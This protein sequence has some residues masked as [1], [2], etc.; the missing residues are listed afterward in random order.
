[1]ANPGEMTDRMLNSFRSMS[2]NTTQ[3]HHLFGREK[4][5]YTHEGHPSMWFPSVCVCMCN[6]SVRT[7][8]LEASIDTSMSPLHKH[9]RTF[10]QHSLISQYNDCALSLRP[11]SFT[12]LSALS[13]KNVKYQV[14]LHIH[15]I[16]TYHWLLSV[17]A[18]VKID[19]WNSICALIKHKTLEYIWKHASEF[20]Y[21]LP[22]H[23]VLLHWLCFSL[24]RTRQTDYRTFTNVI[25]HSTVKWSD[26][27][28]D[29]WTT[30][31]FPSLW[32]SAIYTDWGHSGSRLIIKTSIFTATFSSSS[33]CPKA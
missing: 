2:V 26:N 24:Q 5:Q 20:L 22:R 21:I 4:C 6:S 18:N 28:V 25:Q 8:A 15:S 9:T 14:S 11:F 17:C 12:T 30:S 16:G 33:Y 3:L 31:K 23:D 7:L 13:S 1:M 32:F 10:T 29:I 27:A 19:Q